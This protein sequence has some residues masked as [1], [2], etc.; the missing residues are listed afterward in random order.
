M[1][2]HFLLIFAFF[3]FS[4]CVFTN[5]YHIS[6]FSLENII[7]PDG[8]MQVYEK[9]EYE[10]DYDYRG[11]KRYLPKARYVTIED[12]K[13]WAE[14]LPVTEKDFSVNN[15]REFDVSVWLVPYKSPFKVDHKRFP[16]LVLNI[17]Y[18]AKYIVE[19]GVD[20]SQLFRQF[21]GSG[22]DVPAHNVEVKFVFPSNIFPNQY[23]IHADFENI[24]NVV[25]NVFTLKAEEITAYTYGEVRFVFDAPIEEEYTVKNSTL[26]KEVIEKVEN[27]YKEQ[28]E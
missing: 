10:F 6:S 13:I 26:T 9:I 27:E 20:C 3:V 1:K 19:D 7:F 23:Y 28:K 18:T 25:G 14:G 8:S 17:M 4:I 16:K 12:L 21:W 2:K 5:N 22:W 11:L 24:V 15:E